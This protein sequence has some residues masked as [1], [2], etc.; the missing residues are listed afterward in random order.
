MTRNRRKSN[1]MKNIT[2]AA[3]A[4][5]K[6]SSLNRYRM[7]SNTDSIKPNLLTGLFIGREDPPIGLYENSEDG[8]GMLLLTETAAHIRR[9]N[10]WESIRFYNISRVNME[11]IPDVDS[12]SVTLSDG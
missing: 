8:I 3:I 6:L 1:K 4:Q 11:H 10:A 5:R 9:H 12:L 2:V 7:I